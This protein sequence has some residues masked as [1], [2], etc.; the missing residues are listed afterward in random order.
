MNILYKSLCSGTLAMSLIAGALAPVAAAP[1]RAPISQWG[2][3]DIIQIHST[4]QQTRRA[5]PRQNRFERRNGRYY[6]NGHRGYQQ[7]RAGYRQ[8]NG[9]WFPAAAFAVGVII[10]G[11]QNN[12]SAHVSWC[13]DR[14]RSYRS[15]DDTF[16]PYNGPRKRCRSPY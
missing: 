5:E 16:Q 13:Y 14:Y 12:N 11:S 7:R 4:R 9:Y 6:Y 15:S 3:S 2:Q 8:Y 1:P 10:G